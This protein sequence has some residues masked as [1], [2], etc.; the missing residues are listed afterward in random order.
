MKRLV[1][2][3][4]S[5]GIFLRAKFAKVNVGM[6]HHDI[7]GD[8]YLATTYVGVHREFSRHSCAFYFQLAIANIN[9]IVPS[10]T[11]PFTYRI[12]NYKNLQCFIHEIKQH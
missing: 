1:V 3:G 9:T 2:V 6:L 4:Y 12:R 5:I 10:L 8:P 11:C 7:I